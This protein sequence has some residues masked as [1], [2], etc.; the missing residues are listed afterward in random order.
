MNGS[1]SKRQKNLSILEI[2]IRPPTPPKH[3]PPPLFSSRTAH[4]L[5]GMGMGFFGGLLAMVRWARYHTGPKGVLVLFAA[6]AFGALVGLDLHST[7]RWQAFGRYT[8]AVRLGLACSSAA[9]LTALAGVLVGMVDKTTFGS[10]PSSA[11]FSASVP[12]SASSGTSDASTLRNGRGN[13]ERWPLSKRAC[14]RS[15]IGIL[16]QFSSRR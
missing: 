16:W 10:L 4:V 14:A 7:R 5:S 2:P 1:V 3:D 15:L 9:A 13:C 8:I 12:A 6:M 11:P